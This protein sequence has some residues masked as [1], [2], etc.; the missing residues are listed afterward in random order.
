MNNPSPV[1]GESD[2]ARVLFPPQEKDRASADDTLTPGK[3]EGTPGSRGAP[4]TSGT[5]SGRSSVAG[6]PQ[7]ADKSGATALPPKDRDSEVG[8]CHVVS[9]VRPLT[10]LA[11]QCILCRDLIIKNKWQM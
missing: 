11:T 9:V 2:G 8:S 1:Q 6:V 4:N 5:K 10:G 7:T 3:E